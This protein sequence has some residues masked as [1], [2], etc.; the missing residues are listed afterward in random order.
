MAENENK[1]GELITLLDENGK[2]V[3]C[4]F[5]DTIEYE[6]ALYCVLT[7]VTGE[8]GYEEGSCY[9]FSISDKGDEMVDLLPVEDEDLLNAVFEKFLENNSEEGCSGDCSD[10]S[11][12]E[13]KE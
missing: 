13:G 6:N 9:I 7:P 12:C 5:L 8:E 1:A 11:G 10:C 3:Q 2:E 4:E